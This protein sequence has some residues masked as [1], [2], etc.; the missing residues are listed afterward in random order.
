MLLPSVNYLIFAPFFLFN[1]FEVKSPLF[2]TSGEGL[3]WVSK[4]GW[5]SRLHVFFACIHAG[6]HFC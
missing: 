2:W 5:I 6:Q 3:P 1:F 4:P